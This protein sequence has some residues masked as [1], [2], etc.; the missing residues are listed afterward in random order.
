MPAG[1]LHQAEDTVRVSF[2]PGVSFTFGEHSTW[3][4][5]TARAD[6]MQSPCEHS[7][8]VTPSV[9][10]ALILAPSPDP[11]PST[12]PNPDSSLDPDCYLGFN[13]EPGEAPILTLT[14]DPCSGRG[15]LDE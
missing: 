9:V 15:S 2:T 10:L 1:P 12:T 14:P 7:L 13:S 11:S 8:H 3:P 6:T 4:M 5:H